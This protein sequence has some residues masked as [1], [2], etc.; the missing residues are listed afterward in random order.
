[1]MLQKIEYLHFNP[2]RRGLVDKPEYWRYSSAASYY[3]G[4]VPVLD[5]DRLAG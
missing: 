2:V 1:M 5:I 3:G 4:G